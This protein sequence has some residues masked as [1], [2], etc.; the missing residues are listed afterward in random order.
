MWS[1]RGGGPG[2]PEHSPRSL[3]PW[4]SVAAPSRALSHSGVLLPF[5]SLV[6]PTAASPRFLLHLLSHPSVLPTAP[7]LG[8]ERRGWGKKTVCGPA[9]SI[10]L[11]PGFWALTSLRQL[12]CG[13]TS[14]SHGNCGSLIPEP[15][16]KGWGDAGLSNP[17]MSLDR[18]KAVLS[19]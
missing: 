2:E 5:P 9:V 14:F 6:G 7:A 3:L 11:C 1:P 19:T 4:F 15:P 8:F 12:S 17:A 10:V 16:V 13:L 18:P